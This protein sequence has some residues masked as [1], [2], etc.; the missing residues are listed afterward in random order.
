MNIKIYLESANSVGLVFG[1]L[2]LLVGA[3]LLLILAYNKWLCRDK[4]SLVIIFCILAI[5]YLLLAC[6]SILSF[7]PFLPDANLY[8]EVLQ[9][10]SLDLRWPIGVRTF[11]YFNK[12]ISMLSG[13]DMFIHG[14]LNSFFFAWALVLIWGAWMK[15]NQKTLCKMPKLHLRLFLFLGMIWPAALFF[16][17][18]PLREVLVLFFWAFFLYG[19]VPNMP[20]KRCC[21][22]SRL[23]TA[24]VGGLG[25][26]LL[27]PQFA[28][29]LLVVWF[30]IRFNFSWRKIPKLIPYAFLLLSVG[31]L[32]V[33]H[34]GLSYLFSPEGMANARNF[35][36]EEYMGQT[37]KPVHWKA[38]VDV[39]VDLPILLIYFMS[40]PLV[41]ISNPFYM[42]IGSI[43]AFFVLLVM[44]L[45]VVLLIKGRLE[46]GGKRWLFV[47]L[48]SSSSLALYEFYVSGAVRH[49]MPIV[50]ML[51]PPAA[52]ELA[53]IVKR[54]SQSV[55]DD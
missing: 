11:Y 50:L 3:V 20:D 35:R 31:I 46:K 44:L 5:H 8:F 33:K 14:A 38:W 48:I 34:L 41:V 39:F 7:I 19:V 21:L 23:V 2:I 30:F 28:P 52:V 1:V 43:D 29:L 9:A 53:H 51:L 12:P 27:R 47:A 49:R 16:V 36:V 32:T 15:I 37:Y 55:R 24:I 45:N 4:V 10:E 18:P 6:D 17:S 54:F 40:S 25:V 26:T 22:G 42:L 13:G